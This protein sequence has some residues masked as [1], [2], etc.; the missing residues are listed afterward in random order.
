M[1][2]TPPAMDQPKK[3]SPILYIGVGCLVL[4]LL[5]CVTF[6]AGMWYVASNAERWATAVGAN[7][8]ADVISEMINESE[9]PADQKDRINVRVAELRDG[10]K[11]GELTFE[12]LGGVLEKLGESPLLHVA[13]VESWSKQYIEPSAL[14]EQE[15]AAAR[16]SIDRFARGIYE[17]DIPQEATS[18][19]TAPITTVDEY[20]D[21]Q[22][23]DN[24]T[25][26]ELKEVI[27]LAK[28][29][30]DEAGVPDEPFEINYADEIDKAIDEG[31]A[32]PTAD[33]FADMEDDEFEV[34]G[35]TG[36]AIDSDSSFITPE[37]EPATQE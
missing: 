19:V 25:T 13:L 12:Q 27:E 10:I 24:P 37:P 33:P 30:A 1:S 14:T 9:I 3:T 4:F 32:N 6:C 15:K 22:M 26:E 7:V 31:L 20:G 18:E 28:A 8:T 11:S 21:E 17:G 5:A 36:P 29:K 2:Q 23:K 35:G 34:G 16:R